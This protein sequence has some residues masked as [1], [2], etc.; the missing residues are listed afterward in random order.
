[1]QTGA[2]RGGG[3]GSDNSLFRKTI[4]H[5]MPLTIV[6]AL[7]ASALAMKP[8]CGRDYISH[9]HRS[10]SIYRCPFELLKKLLIGRCDALCAK[11]VKS[12]T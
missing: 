3:P 8:G 5:G 7:S 1:M 10:S 2:V 9:I 12:F 11:H 6:N 4:G